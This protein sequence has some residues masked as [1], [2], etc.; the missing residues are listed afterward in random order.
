MHYCAKNRPGWNCFLNHASSS[1]V[2]TLP[3]QDV[4]L[5]NF[6]EAFKVTKDLPLD[7][8]D[9]GREPLF[10][11]FVEDG[12]GVGDFV[13]IRSRELVEPEIISFSKLL[14]LDTCKLNVLK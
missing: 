11:D 13:G 9:V 2:V 8:A 12:V 4:R 6:F 3:T 1:S 14:M 10:D 5:N 7:F